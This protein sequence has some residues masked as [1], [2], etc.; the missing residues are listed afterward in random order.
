MSLVYYPASVFKQK[1]EIVTNFDDALLANIRIMQQAMNDHRA[2]GIGAN[3]CGILPSSETPKENDTIIMINPHIT[4]KSVET[5]TCI[6]A[7][8]SLPGIDAQITR[9]Q[10]ITV[11]YQDIHQQSHTLTATGFLSTV[12][13][14][15]IDYLDGIVYLDYLPKGK[16]RLLREKMQKY[17][18]KTQRHGHG[19][20]QNQAVNKHNHNHN[21]SPGSGHTHKHQENHHYHDG[22]LCTHQH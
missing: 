2:I 17:I 18:K 13:Q 22:K 15:E 12:I 11:T 4:E 9:P 3:M 6:E 14:H 5:Q 7:S 8:L 21:L 20:N 19:D 16:A 10:T 1:S